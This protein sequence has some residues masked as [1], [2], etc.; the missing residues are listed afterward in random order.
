MATQVAEELKTVTYA[1]THDE[2]RIA[3][4]EINVPIAL[5]AFSASYSRERR[6]RNQN[7]YRGLNI[8]GKG[9]NIDTSRL[10]TRS[11]TFN[12]D[13]I[14]SSSF[15]HKTHMNGF[16]STIEARTATVEGAEPI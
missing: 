11:E 8:S 14:E 4:Y 12:K 1:T 15:T 5:S 10:H 7:I 3:K 2:R 6:R 13:C 16:C 9:D